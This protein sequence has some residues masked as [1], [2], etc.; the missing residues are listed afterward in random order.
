MPRHWKYPSEKSSTV[1]KLLKYDR[2]EANLE[3]TQLVVIAGL[4]SFR[5]SMNLLASQAAEAKDPEKSW[6]ELAQFDCYACS[7]APLQIYTVR[8]WRRFGGQQ[9]ESPVH[10]PALTALYFPGALR[11]AEN[12]AAKVISENIRNRLASHFAAG[13]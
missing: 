9:V 12:R 5:E 7:S 10:T 3:K 4:V 11:N 2:A 13:T 1:Q 8:D 6:P